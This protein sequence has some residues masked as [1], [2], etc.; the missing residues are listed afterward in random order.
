MERIV[1]P[2]TTDQIV[3]TLL[4]TILVAGFSGYFFYDGYVG[5]PA[6]N[7]EKAVEQLDPVPESLPPMQPD[8]NK[9]KA[10]EVAADVT[11]NRRTIGQIIDRLG[12]PGWR[13][14]RRDDVRWFGPGGVLKLTLIGDL[15]K[16]ATYT[17]GHKSESDLLT[18]KILAIAL[19]PFAILMLGKSVAT[20]TGR[21]TLSDAGL[22]LRGKPVIPFDAMKGLDPELFKKKGIV[23]LSYTQDGQDRSVKL[24]EYKIREF[25]PIIAEICSR[26]EIE[27]PLP[28]PKKDAT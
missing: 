23:V 7:L 17:S 12:E 8:I 19:L 13:S 21:T 10:A 9:A 28:P 25:R 6:K 24:D 5:Y 27:D 11:A 2:Q 22:K 16:E 1:T 4:L 18:Q 15:V 3:R 20:L 26:C 14:P